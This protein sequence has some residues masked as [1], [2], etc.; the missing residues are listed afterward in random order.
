ML[1]IYPDIEYL[2]QGWSSWNWHMICL[3]ICLL[4][5][6]LISKTSLL[7]NIFYFQFM[8]D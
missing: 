5:L 6:D 8:S 4:L 7:E 1:Q 2:S 3:K